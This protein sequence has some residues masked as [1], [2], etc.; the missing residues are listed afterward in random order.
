MMILLYEAWHASPVL[1]GSSPHEDGIDQNDKL[2]ST[3]NDGSIMSLSL[4]P[5]PFIEAL[6]S[7]RGETPFA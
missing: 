5:Q 3:G 2:A 4:G 6:V 1:P 7:A